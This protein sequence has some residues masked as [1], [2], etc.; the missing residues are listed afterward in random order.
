[1]LLARD[2]A[3]I[4]RILERWRDEL[5]VKGNL[6]YEKANE[7]KDVCSKILGYDLWMKKAESNQ[8]KMKLADEYFMDKS[9]KRVIKSLQKLKMLNSPYNLFKIR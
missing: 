5:D 3:L 9:L 6:W 7:F 4:L 1:M 8:N 2:H